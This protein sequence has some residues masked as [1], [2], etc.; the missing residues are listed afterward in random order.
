MIRYQFNVLM[1]QLMGA[2]AGGGGGEAVS[3]EP[4]AQAG[5]AGNLGGGDPNQGQP[6]PGSGGDP[7][8][9]QPLPGGQP[10]LQPDRSG[11]EAILNDDGTFAAN[12]FQG[13]KDLEQ[14]AGALG[15]FKDPAGLAKSYALLERN[16]TVPSDDAPPEAVEAYR[17]ANGIPSDAKGYE[18]QI[19]EEIPDHIK[20]A[21]ESELPQWQE[22]F[23]EANLT[24]TQAQ[25]LFG[26]QM[27]MLQEAQKQAESQQYQSEQEA[28]QSLQKDW[29][30]AYE[31][32]LDKA[33]KVFDNYAAAAGIDPSKVTFT[34]D[35]A[36]AKIMAAV[37]S[38]MSESNFTKTAGETP[39]ELRGGKHE[40]D[41]IM[42]NEKHPDY[43]SYWNPSDSRHREV[44]DRVARMLQ[45][46]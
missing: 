28:I 27:A 42:T 33:Q 2:G 37:G 30:P 40:A 12:W 14:F 1:N 10:N 11:A 15:K 6:Q 41:Q 17:A 4:G 35:P 9:G 16:R 24:P 21:V 23:L 8:G 38:E 29:G 20:Q 5:A 22:Q 25:R 31:A 32:N 39:A 7:N 45:G 43:A 18:M 26:K 13:N 34:N 3:A 19:P 46:G 44:Q 36:F